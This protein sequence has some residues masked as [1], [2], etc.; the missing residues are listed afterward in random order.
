M[1][2]RYFNGNYI[3]GRKRLARWLQATGRNLGL[4]AANGFVPALVSSFQNKVFLNPEETDPLTLFAATTERTTNAT[5][6]HDGVLKWGPHDHYGYTDDLSYHSNVGTTDVGDLLTEDSSAGNHSVSRTM[7][8]SGIS[9]QQLTW[10]MKVKPEGRDYCMLFLNRFGGFGDR[11]EARFDL[12]N[13]L[14]SVQAQGT[15]TAVSSSIEGPDSDGFYTIRVTGVPST[16]SAQAAAQF[17]L[18]DEY[19]FT[20]AYPGD[21]SSGMRIKEQT[22]YRSD[23]G[24]MAPAPDGTDYVPNDTG[25]ARY[26]PRYGHTNPETGVKGVL[27][28]TGARTNLFRNNMWAGVALQSTSQTVGG[29][30]IDG[31]DGGVNFEVVAS[32]E[33]SGIPYIDVRVNG[34]N[35]SGATLF[36]DVY[37]AASVAASPGDQVNVSAYLKLVSGTIPDDGSVVIYAHCRDSGGVLLATEPTVSIGDDIGASLE[38]FQGSGTAPAS[39]TQLV[40]KGLFVRV[41]NAETLDFTIRIGGLQAEFV[42]AANPHASSLIPTSGATVTRNADTNG[43]AIDDALMP[44]PEPVVIGSELVTNGTFDSDISG[45]SD[46]SSAGGTV[47]WNAAGH[48]DI[49]N[50]TGTAR[51]SQSNLAGAGATGKVWRLTFDVVAGSTGNGSLYVSDDGLGAGNIVSETITPDAGP[52]EFFF[53]SQ[54]DDL[55]LSFRNFGAGTTFSIDNVSVQEISPRAVC[56]AVSGEVSYGD[57]DA[58]ATVRFVQWLQD[59]D[60][61]LDMRLNADGAKTGRLANYH[62]NAADFDN[63]THEN[64]FTPG[65]NVAFA[66]ATRFTDNE[67]LTA[68]DGARTAGPANIPA[69]GLVDVSGADFK[70]AQVFSGTISEVVV[71]AEDIGE[72]GIEGAST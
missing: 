23:L 17:Y 10:R 28:E 72:A 46:D 65:A 2:T 66:I 7:S 50:T 34:T 39:T 44:W 58:T 31:S 26:I 4:Y 63:H 54:N 61:Y 56:I 22:V 40:N 48:A 62:N 6:W 25:S 24:G 9:V 30:E 53:I 12:P 8:A 51:F 49:I 16:T 33:E 13:R 19:D 11:V 47:A 64:Q 41:P 70:V 20:L 55:D 15:A 5:M 27:V 35:T 36:F 68:R 38:R 42:T 3:S 21:G 14:T 29:V 37:D 18:S 52:R 71:W 60:N 67:I 57:N 45:W 69:N 1:V 59:N 43:L 32:G